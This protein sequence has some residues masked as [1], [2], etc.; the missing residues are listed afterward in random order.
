MYVPGTSPLVLWL[1]L[2]APKA[3]SPDSIPAWGTSSCVSQLKVHMPQLKIPCA[4]KKKKKERDP[5]CSLINNFFKVCPW[6]AGGS[7]PRLLL[8]SHLVYQATALSFKSWWKS[9]ERGEV[10]PASQTPG[11]VRVTQH[12]VAGSLGE[13]TYHM[14]P[15]MQGMLRNAAPACKSVATT[16]QDDL[17]WCPPPGSHSQHSP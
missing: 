9:K 12:L 2:Q 1:R 11:L 8:G 13:W 6:L 16:L 7:P 10:M 14:A 5:V 17:Q 4:A 3:G 15:G